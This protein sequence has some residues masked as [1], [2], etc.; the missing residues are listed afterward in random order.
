MEWVCGEK[1][2]QGVGDPA[3]HR[4]EDD[5]V[6]PTCSE[7]WSPLAQS[8]AQWGFWQVAGLNV[9]YTPGLVYPDQNLQTCFL[10]TCSL[11]RTFFIL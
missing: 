10:V 8:G 9:L 5:L 11:P 3:C 6:D 2:V 4:S 1:R 7:L